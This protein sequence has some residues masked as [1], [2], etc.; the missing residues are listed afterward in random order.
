MTLLARH[1]WDRALADMDLALTIEPQ[2]SPCYLFRGILNAKK[3]RLLPTCRDLAG[4]LLTFDQTEFQ[5]FCHIELPRGTHPCR[6]EIGLS[7]KSKSDPS[8]PERHASGIDEE[9]VEMGM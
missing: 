5:F 7:W 6:F 1:D 4:F 9:C 8:K 2:G 3:G